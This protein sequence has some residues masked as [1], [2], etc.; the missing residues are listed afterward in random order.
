MRVYVNDFLLNFQGRNMIIW[1][2]NLSM[3]HLE[4]LV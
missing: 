4:K 2:S 3:T 1:R